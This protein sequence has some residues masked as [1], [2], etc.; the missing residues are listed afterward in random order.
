M[1]GASGWRRRCRRAR[2]P[3][4]GV[5]GGLPAAGYAAKLDTVS[6][7]FLYPASQGRW[8]KPTGRRRRSS[9]AGQ[10]GGIIIRVS[11]VQIPPPLPS[12]PT[13]REPC[14]GSLGLRA[15][16]LSVRQSRL[17]RRRGA[18]DLGTQ[19]R[20]RQD[21]G[22]PALLPD[23]RFGRLGTTCPG[24]WQVAARNV[25]AQQGA[26]RRYPRPVELRS[27]PPQPVCALHSGRWNVGPIPRG[28]HAPSRCRRQACRSRD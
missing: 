2:S 1:C 5:R 10:S 11:G 23:F 6:P 8:R 9:S 4:Q 22:S 14:W 13:L 28:R 20:S 7:G 19:S 18:T 25:P 26:A 3:R 27:T 12:H 21:S 15:T 24:G 17:R 16:H